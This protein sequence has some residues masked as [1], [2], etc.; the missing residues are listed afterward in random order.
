MVPLPIGEVVRIA[1]EYERS[2]RLDDASRLL[3]HVLRAAP[4]QGDALHLAGIVAFRQGDLEGSLALMQRSLEHGIDTP[5][6][7]RNICE[8]YRALGRLDEALATAQRASALAPADPL[9]LHNQAIIHYHRVELDAAL[10]CADRALRI[11]PSLPGAHFVRAESL[12]LRG[13]WAEGWEEY[14]WRFR[15]AGAAPLMPPTNRPQWDGTPLPDR[16]LLLIADQ[17][18]GDVIQFA[19]YI[20]W[21]TERCTDIAIACSAEVQPLLR[22]IAPAARL[23]VRWEDAPGYAAFCALSGLPRLA[24]TRVDSVPAPVPY[25]RADPARAAQWAERLAGLVP[26][27]FR[28]IGVIWAGRPTHNNDRNRSATLAEFMPLANVAGIALLAL[29][30]GPKTGQAGTYYG[31]APLINIGAEI[32]DYDDTMAILDNIDLLVTVDTS[33]AHLAGAMGR[34]VWVMLPRAPDWRWL[35]E[36][37]DTPWYPSVRLFRQKNVRRWDD[38]MREIA[39]GL[40]SR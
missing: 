4:D 18:F 1:N 15:I 19:R 11:D 34:P 38:V 36:R 14:E 39:A 6:Y 12:L 16:T 28:R 37:G 22:Q 17:G 33:V 13:D 23:F 24:G 20:A 26:R 27:G 9:C 2:G 10:D 25:L 7:L 35:L 40:V 8:V 32:E 31:R 30:K 5:L 21:A 29:Q 3:G